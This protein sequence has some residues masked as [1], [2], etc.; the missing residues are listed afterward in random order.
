MTRL[1]HYVLAV[2]LG[3]SIDRLQFNVA[4]EFPNLPFV[5]L[6][7]GAFTRLASLRLVVA[8]TLH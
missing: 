2:C 6:V 4:L 7:V 1:A 8:A 5:G 3:P